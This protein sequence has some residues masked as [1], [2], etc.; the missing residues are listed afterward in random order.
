MEKCA[1]LTSF[2]VVTIHRDNHVEILFNEIILM[3]VFFIISGSLLIQVR[4]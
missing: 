1:L 4:N 3:L 2:F